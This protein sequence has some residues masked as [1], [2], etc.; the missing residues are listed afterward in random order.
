MEDFH[1]EKLTEENIDEYVIEEFKQRWER[2]SVTII[3]NNN[4]DVSLD[5][6]AKELLD[7]MKGWNKLK[8][9][10]ITYLRMHL[11]SN[12]STS[13]YK[14]LEEFLSKK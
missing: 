3:P 7:N 2:E 4:L 8:I 11:E 13:E 14:D 10:K 9:K 1:I 6:S 5:I 12:L